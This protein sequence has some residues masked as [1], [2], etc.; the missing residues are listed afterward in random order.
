MRA[1]LILAAGLMVATLAPAMAEDLFQDAAIA[2]DELSANRG[3][4]DGGTLVQANDSTLSGSNTGNVSVGG[5]A[6]KYSGTIAPATVT[7]NHGIT[8][9]MQNTGDLV[10]MNNAT[11]VNV[12]MR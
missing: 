5:G 6:Q 7:N 1:P 4:T 10:N 8:A 2:P 3:G 11:S 9:V 12:Y